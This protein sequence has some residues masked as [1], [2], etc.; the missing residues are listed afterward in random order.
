M[1]RL[2]LLPFLLL[3]AVPA[4]AENLKVLTGGAFKPVLVDMLPEF[5]KQTGHKVTVENDTAGALTRR[6]MAGEA[7][8]IVILPL[9]NLDQLSAEGKVIDD[10]MTPFGK[11]GVGVAVALSAPQPNIG[12]TEGLRRTLLDARTVAY[13]DPAMGGTSGIYVARLF[14]QLGIASQ[15]RAKSV[16]VHDGLAGQAVARGQAEIALQQASEL[17]L[18]PTVKFAGLLPE[19][20]QNWTVY[21]GALSPAARSKDAALTLMSALSDPGMEPM[22]KRRGLEMP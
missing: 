1:M 17:R 15:M 22:L 4:A 2:L 12:S 11:V 19:A 8:D 7:F 5:E 18:V 16:L 21:T 3:L 6:V 14:E 10:S 13:I 20:I 9:A